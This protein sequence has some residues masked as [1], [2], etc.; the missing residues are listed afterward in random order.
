ME[1]L[2]LHLRDGDIS[3]HCSSCARVF[4][5]DRTAPFLGQLRAMSGHL[6]VVREAGGDAEIFELA[7]VRAARRA[8]AVRR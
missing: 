8:R 5:L 4:T 2:Q 3:F 1:N 6:C 7:A